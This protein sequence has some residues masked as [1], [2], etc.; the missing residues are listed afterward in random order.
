MNAGEI[1]I[2]KNPKHPSSEEYVCI[3]LNTSKR[4]RLKTVYECR[5]LIAGVHY[6]CSY[7]EEFLHVI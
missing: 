5:F 3:I 6:N 7:N 2:W 4:K 1:N